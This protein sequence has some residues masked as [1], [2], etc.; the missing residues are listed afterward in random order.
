MICSISKECIEE[1]EKSEYKDCISELTINNYK[2]VCSKINSDK[3]Q[4]FYNNPLEFYSIW[5]ENSNFVEMFQ[6]SLIKSL[7]L[8]Y[9]MS[10]QTDENGNLCPFALTSIRRE[11]NSNILND[12]CKSKLCTESAINIYKNYDLDQMAAYESLSTTTWSYS[13]DE[14]TVAKNYFLN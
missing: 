8:S 7:K 11:G 1:Q 9:Q 2:N 3:C 5:R 13:Y 6:S 12:T 10:C 14:L 4:K